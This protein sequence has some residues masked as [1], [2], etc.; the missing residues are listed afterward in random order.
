MMICDREDT[1]VTTFQQ[2]CVPLFQS[3]VLVHQTL[4]M[5][6][7]ISLVKLPDTQLMGPSPSFSILSNPDPIGRTASLTQPQHMI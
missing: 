5:N 3:L 7:H 2:N 4:S 1:W 6:I